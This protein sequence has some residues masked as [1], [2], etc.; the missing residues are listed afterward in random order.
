MNAPGRL[1][2]LRDGAMHVLCRGNG[3][4]TVILDA[5]L[6]GCSLD[7]AL[8]QEHVAKF[9]SVCTFDRPGYGWSAPRAGQRSS[10][11]IVREIEELLQAAG[12]AGPYVVVGHSFGG[13]NMR[14]FA[15]RNREAVRAL[16]LVDASHTEGLER[17]PRA[18]W[19]AVRRKLRLARW[20][21]PTG[22]LHLADALG[23]IPETRLYA[24]FPDSARVP[25]RRHF[26]RSGTIVTTCRELDALPSSQ[27]QVAAAG[28]LGQLPV[29]VLSSVLTLHPDRD[30]PRAVSARELRRVWQLLQAELLA[31]S[32]Q[33]RQVLVEESGHYIAIERPQA[34]VQAIRDTVQHARRAPVEA[35]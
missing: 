9:T 3:S 25:A 29:V 23:L 20:I 6:A 32:T 11:V 22:A 30:L 28:T 24:R 35:T 16:V 14:L 10:G 18:Y 21:A 26:C 12:V 4:P 19:D 7:W 31:L 17:L 2:H 27:R 34:V 15:A 33:S 13:L 1:V 5:G 8:V